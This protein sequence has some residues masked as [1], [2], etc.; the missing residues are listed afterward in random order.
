[1]RTVVI[2]TTVLVNMSASLKNVVDEQSTHANLAITFNTK[3]MGEG[4]EHFVEQH[5]TGDNLAKILGVKHYDLANIKSIRVHPPTTSEYTSSSF[6]LVLGHGTEEANNFEPL[7]TPHRSAHLNGEGD[8]HSFH[9]FHTGSGFGPYDLHVHPTDNQIAEL[10]QDNLPNRRLARWLRESTSTNFE[11][12]NEDSIH[13]GVHKSVIPGAPEKTKYIV[14]KGA[15][16]KDGSFKDNA[17]YRLFQYNNMGSSKNLPPGVTTLSSFENQPAYVLSETQFNDIKGK[18]SKALSP[19]SPW[20]KG[21]TARLTRN[22]AGSAPSAVTF[23][24]ELHRE[25]LAPSHELSG[26]K[27]PTLTYADFLENHADE[28]QIIKKGESGVNAIDTQLAAI[29]PDASPELRAQAQTTLLSN[30]HM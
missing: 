7:N 18:L 6:G 9:G 17:I 4:P 29:H 21:F 15:M 28:R 16:D 25:P 26:I 14:T 19:A 27:A 13:D 22:G 1:M 10:R 3:G 2:C 23:Q 20:N 5:I 11:L 12:L 8:I 30:N 24:T